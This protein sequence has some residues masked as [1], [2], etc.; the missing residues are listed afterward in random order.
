[1]WDGK[2]GIQFIQ[3]RIICRTS[4]LKEFAET[5]EY[6]LDINIP[7]IGEETDVKNLRKLRIICG[8]N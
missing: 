8:G 7:D 3:E 4:H 6:D 1:M 2:E 5:L